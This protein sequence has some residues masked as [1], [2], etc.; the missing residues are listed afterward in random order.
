MATFTFFC[1]QSNSVGLT[2]EQRDLPDRKAAETHARALLKA[3]PTCDSVTVC[4]EAEEFEVRSAPP[5]TGLSEDPEDRLLAALSR[6]PFTEAHLAVILASADGVVTY[7]NDAA[8]ALYGWRSGEAHGRQILDLTPAATSRADAARILQQLAAGVPWSGEIL[9]RTRHGHPLSA[10]VADF[11]VVD[12]SGRRAVVGISVEL[13]RRRE[14]D[15][16]MAE[17]IQAL[18]SSGALATPPE[19][20][21]TPRP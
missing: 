12:A 18:R 19:L 9:L 6:P 15:S 4:A 17:I 3:H 14:V 1:W 7:W 5:P 2:F 20:N 16:R 11:P 13:T 8:E 21:P 10:Y